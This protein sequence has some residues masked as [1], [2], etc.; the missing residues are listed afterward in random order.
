MPRHLPDAQKLPPVQ[1]DAHFGFIPKFHTW[2]EGLS[3]KVASYFWENISYSAEGVLFDV[4]ALGNFEQ[5]IVAL[6]VSNAKLKIIERIAFLLLKAWLW[7][8]FLK[9]LCLFLGND[10]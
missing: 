3:P 4:S 6:T 1:T 2:S 8:I 9:F 5:L 10:E 7:N